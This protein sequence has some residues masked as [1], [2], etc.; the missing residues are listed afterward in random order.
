MKFLHSYSF[1]YFLEYQ[2]PTLTKFHQVRLD[3]VKSYQNGFIK[4]EIKE[5]LVRSA[6][7]L[8]KNNR[9][10]CCVVFDIRECVYCNLEGDFFISDT[11]PGVEIEA[12]AGIPD[13]LTQ[14]G[15]C[16]YLNGECA[17]RG[18]K[19]SVSCCCSA[20]ICPEC[21]TPVNKFRLT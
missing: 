21:M 15:K 12:P 20:D 18:G 9:S 11:P 3:A 19:V 5:M 17:D 10:L 4:N 13:G 1:P 6:V 7:E 8:S 16:G 2:A 14:C